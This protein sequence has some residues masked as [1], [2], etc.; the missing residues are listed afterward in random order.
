M[1]NLARIIGPAPSEL[2]WEELRMKIGAE[3]ERVRAAIE[4]WRAGGGSS[5]KAKGR[6]GKKKAESGFS[7]SQLRTMAKQL[8]N[9]SM[10]ELNS[11]LAK[12]KEEREDG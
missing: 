5:F 2:P 9:I 7:D 8:G 10:R 3:R 11:L 12:A 6:T 4:Y 1:D